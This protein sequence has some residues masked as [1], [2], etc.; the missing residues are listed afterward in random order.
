[1]TTKPNQTVLDIFNGTS[2]TTSLAIQ[3]GRK[4]I[5]YDTDTKSIEFAAKRLQKA[6]ENLLSKEEIMYL[7]EN[8]FEEV[9]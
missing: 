4:A 9:A 6:E 5:G 2:T 8:Y 1:M 3:L 7:T